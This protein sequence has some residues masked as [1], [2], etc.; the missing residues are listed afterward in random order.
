MSNKYYYELR[1]KENNYDVGEQVLIK[2]SDRK[3]KLSNRFE[4]PFE[5]L[6]KNKDLYKV[7]SLQTNEIGTKYISQLKLFRPRENN[8]EIATKSNL[9]DLANINPGMGKYSGP[10]EHQRNIDSSARA[11]NTTRRRFS[12]LTHA[13]NLIVCPNSC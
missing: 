11:A 6:A 13:L 8:D 3:A 5:V 9:V 2:R 4:G 10:V 1:K 12:L 7:K